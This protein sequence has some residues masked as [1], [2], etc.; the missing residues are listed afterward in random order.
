MP[1]SPEASA[2]SCHKNIAVHR[3]QQVGAVCLARAGQSA[4]RDGFDNRCLSCSARWRDAFGH[5]SFEDFAAHANTTAG[6]KRPGTVHKNTKAGTEPHWI[7]EDVLAETS[8]RVCVERSVLV[9][10][11]AEYRKEMGKNLPGSRG[12]KP[13]TMMLRSEQNPGEYEEHFVFQDPDHPYR[14]AVVK[15]ELA[16]V[17]RSHRLD[18]HRNAYESQGKQIHETSARSSVE[19]LSIKS[20]F[21]PMSANKMLKMP[22]GHPVLGPNKPALLHSRRPCPNSCG[23]CHRRPPPSSLRADRSELQK[24]ARP[25]QS[26]RSKPPGATLVPYDSA[27]QADLD[28]I[29]DFEP[30][31]RHPLAD[32]RRKLHVLKSKLPLETLMSEIRMGRSERA[33]RAT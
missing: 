17:R 33:V 11:A 32:I 19:K 20:S 8:T 4:V 28:D 14:R 25:S 3:L 13:Q 29:D 31:G 23:A 22:R 5:P 27:S 1:Q 18:V 16:D 12:P 2:R 7:P 10:T 15:Q 30:E 6:G 24:A 9:L 26:F 21:S